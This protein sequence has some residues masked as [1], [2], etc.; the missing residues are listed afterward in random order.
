MSSFCYQSYLHLYSLTLIHGRQFS[1]LIRFQSFLLYS[2]FHSVPHSYLI[3]SSSCH[4]SFYLCHEL[5]LLADKYCSRCS[6][7]QCWGM[8]LLRSWMI[9][10]C[11]CQSLSKVCFPFTLRLASHFEQ[12][13]GLNFVPLLAI[14]MEFEI[15]S[16]GLY[17]F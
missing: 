7:A 5:F 8:Y 11:V 6:Y 4:F 9:C 3:L 15:Q 12:I 13:I 2:G 10:L 1:F 16:P 14:Y 17:F